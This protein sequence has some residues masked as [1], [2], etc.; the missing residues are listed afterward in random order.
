MCWWV[1][2]NAFDECS[3]SGIT[4]TLF[5]LTAIACSVLAELVNGTIDYS[6]SPNVVRYS[7][8]TTA[9]YQCNS[10]YNIMIIGRDR[11][12]TCTGDG[13]TP[14]GQWNGASPQCSRMF[15]QCNWSCHMIMYT[16]SCGLWDASIYYQ[17]ISWD[18]NNHNIHRDCDL[19][20]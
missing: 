3:C 11:V 20:L 18:T 19:Q 7:Y 13:N 9:T 14:D 8:G 6:R 5:F 10:G 17:W 2:Y 4:H 1:S 16:H 15:Y 12:R